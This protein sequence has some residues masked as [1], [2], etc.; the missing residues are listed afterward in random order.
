MPEEA[1]K[2]VRK[3]AREIVDESHELIENTRRT[4]RE[5]TP[6][7]IRDRVLERFRRR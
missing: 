5:L 3:V 6:R 2:G 1:M 4:R 7:P